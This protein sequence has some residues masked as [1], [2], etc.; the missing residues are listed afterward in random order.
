MN[1][2]IYLRRKRERKP[3][4]FE[5]IGYEGYAEAPDMRCFLRPKQTVQPASSRR[6]KLTNV[7][8]NPV[9]AIRQCEREFE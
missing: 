8:Q 7:I 6:M 5:D 2:C 3:P 4:D 1:V 9:Q